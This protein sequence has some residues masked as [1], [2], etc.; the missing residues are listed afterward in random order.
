MFKNKT[1]LKQYNL[2]ESHVAFLSVFQPQ[3][4]INITVSKQ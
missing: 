2:L 4:D 3:K 1:K